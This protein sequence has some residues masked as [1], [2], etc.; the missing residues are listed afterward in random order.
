MTRQG[1]FWKLEDR[2]TYRIP[3]SWEMYGH[4]KI[5]ATTLEEAIEIAESNESLPDG[6]YVVDS[7]RVDHDILQDL[8]SE[9]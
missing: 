3:C 8:N 6:D 4:M 9:G 2:K 5:K 7:F 1:T